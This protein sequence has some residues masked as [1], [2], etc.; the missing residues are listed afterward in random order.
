M[1][2]IGRRWGISKI[3]GLLKEEKCKNRQWLRT[4]S[5]ELP[6]AEECDPPAPP[7]ADTEDRRNESSI[8]VML[9][10]S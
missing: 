8:V 6:D 9:M 4:G 1:E 2:W 3:I 10:T 5:V 7:V